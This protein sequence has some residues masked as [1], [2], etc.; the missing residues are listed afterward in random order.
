[1]LKQFTQPS[2][3]ERESKVTLMLSFEIYEPEIVLLESDVQILLKVLN[4]G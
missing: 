3:V 4:S 2:A 1:M